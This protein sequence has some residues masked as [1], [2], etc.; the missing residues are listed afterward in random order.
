MFNIRLCCYKPIPNKMYVLYNLT[1]KLTLHYNVCYD[2][3]Y[4]FWWYKQNGSLYMY[5]FNFYTNT[6]KNI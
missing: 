6:N 5:A 1:H 4:I 3:I 2:Y